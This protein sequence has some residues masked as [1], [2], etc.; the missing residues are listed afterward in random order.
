MTSVHRSTPPVVFIYGLLGVIPF[1]APAP[2]GIVFPDFKG[3]AAH[4][5]ALYGGLILSFLG[6]ARWGFANA[7]PA[8]RAGLISLSMLPTLTGLA[9]L[10]APSGM[11]RLQLLG[12]A[13]ALGLHWLWDVRSDDLPVW[14]PKLRTL[15]TLGA[16]VGLIAGVV[17]LT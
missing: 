2:T 14:Y 17:V 8:P 15:L 7:H 12:L 5:L 4:V 3:L 6:G 9:L 10:A 1:L 11:R 16:V 13:I